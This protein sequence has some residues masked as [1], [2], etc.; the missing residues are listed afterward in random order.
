MKSSLPFRS[1]CLIP[2]AV[3]ACDHRSESP[4]PVT[5]TA[6]PSAASSTPATP[7]REG[8]LVGS[9]PPDF[10]TTA[11]DGSVVHLA[12]LKGKPAV[13]YFYPKDE[14]AGCTKEACSFRDSWDV[15]SKKGVVLVG[16]SADAEESHKAFAAHYQLPFLLVSDTDGKIATSF[17]VPFRGRPRGATVVRHRGRRTRQEGLSQGGRDRARAGDPGGPEVE[18][19]S[20]P[21]N[22]QPSSPRRPRRRDAPAGRRGSRFLGSIQ[23]AHGRARRGP[24][25]FRASRGL[26]ER[27]PRSAERRRGPVREPLGGAATLWLAEPRR[28]EGWIATEPRERRARPQASPIARQACSQWRPRSR[29]MA[30]DVGPGL[31]PPGPV[32]VTYIAYTERNVLMLDGEGVAFG[33]SPSVLEVP[34]STRGAGAP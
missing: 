14:T 33:S 12:A 27:S 11:Q 26:R 32:T 15:L 10:T 30:G 13:V 3:T 5:T 24:R 31:A 18:A 19:L 34:S 8:I 2:L 20:S 4:S 1:T 17:G 21:R 7:P 6:A 28:I 23:R 16:V 29:P 22:A 25:G 9:P